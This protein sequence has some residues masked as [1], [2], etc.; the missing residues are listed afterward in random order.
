MIYLFIHLFI[1]SRLRDVYLRLWQ[2]GPLYNP[3]G[4]VQTPGEVQL[5][6][7]SHT[8]LHIANRIKVI[9]R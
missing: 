4:Q 8:G 2:V 9:R 5:P 7:F 1:H 3:A 6:P